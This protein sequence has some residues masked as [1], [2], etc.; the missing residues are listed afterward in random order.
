MSESLVL[1]DGEYYKQIDGVAMGSPL[2]PTFANI[3]LCFYEQIWLESCPIKFKPVF[4]RRFVDD[5]F[6]LF[7]S[8]E[9]IEKFRTY[10]NCQQ[11]NIKF[12]SEIEEYNC[13]SFLDIKIT[14]EFKSFSTSVYRKPTFSGVF[15][16]FDSFIP[17]SY[18]TGLIWSLLYR[19]FSLCS[20][21]EL[22][23]QEILKE[24]DIC[25]RNSY[26][27]SF[28]DKCVKRFLNKVFVEKNFFLTASKKQL[29]CVLPFIGKKS[30]QLRSRLIKSIQRNL[31]FCS[32]K[33]VFQSTCKLRSLFHFKDTLDK[34]IRSDLVCRYT[35]SNCNV[36][37]YGKTYRH[38]FTG[39][40]EHMG[41][42]NL[43][44]KRVENVKQSAVS[45]HLLQ[46]NCSINFGD[47]DILASETNNFRLLIKESL[48]V[49]RDKPVLNRTT[50][51]FPLKLFD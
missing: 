7:R 16:N 36:T 49:M 30:L 35:C 9:H 19:A 39:A 15:T 47:F 33:V 6:L 2:G 26:P 14:R 4:Y 24:K 22:L 38:F 13:M 25:K 28:I 3:F 45:D 11:P 41:I 27:I 48:L 12:T 37:Y 10:R 21:F 1:F 20:S 50:T 42:P 32:L 34:K 18:K 5:M 29:V 31:Q 40:A 51:S 46:C 8:Y 44:E 23:H 43:T 17:L